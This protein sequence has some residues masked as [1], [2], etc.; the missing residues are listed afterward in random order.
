MV[1]FDPRDLVWI[2]FSKGKF[3]SKL[4][5]QLIMRVNGPFRVVKRLNDNA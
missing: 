4:K 3:P 2:Y 1:R 5:F